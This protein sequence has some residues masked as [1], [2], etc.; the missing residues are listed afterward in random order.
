MNHLTTTTESP[1]YTDHDST[2]LREQ[3]RERFVAAKHRA[4]EGL[5]QA[6]TA[7]G[8]GMERMGEAVQSAAVSATVPM[9]RAGRYMQDSK[10][11]AMG[12]DFLGMVRRNPGTTLL[13]GM[14]L[15]LLL[16]RALS[17]R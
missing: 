14:G 17:P 1:R 6:T 3:G 5:D 12:Q 15:G 7:L 2:S 4:G 8:R 9:Q 16:G 11:G 10:P 13:I